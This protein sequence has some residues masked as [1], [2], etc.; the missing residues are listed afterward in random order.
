MLLSLLTLS[1]SSL[2][3]SG[4]LPSLA[5]QVPVGLFLSLREMLPGLTTVRV[6]REGLRGV[7]G[8][9]GLFPPAPPAPVGGA[10]GIWGAPHGGRGATRPP[11][12]ATLEPG[13]PP[14]PTSPWTGALLDPKV[15]KFVIL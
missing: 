13:A 10:W 15:M 14:A 9:S 5:A 11:Y 8:V 1:F 6:G 2:L 3:L 7:V 4:S 12:G